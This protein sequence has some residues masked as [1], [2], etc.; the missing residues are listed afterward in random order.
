MKRIESV[1]IGTVSQID[2]ELGRIKVMFDFMTPPQ[3]SNWAPIASL[4]AGKKTGARF[5]PEQKDE[6]LIA[7]DR[8]DFEHPYVVGFLWNHV[9]KAPDN[10]EHNR[11]IVTPGGHQLRFEDKPGAKKVIVRTDGG[12]TITMDD[13]QQS[14]EIKGGGR[15]VTMQGGQ[16][17]IT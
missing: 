11:L 16:I 13:T 4:L 5:M 9:D 14:I 8:G 12:L 10:N 15:A 6:V 7:F 3:E 1:A 17:K 2:A